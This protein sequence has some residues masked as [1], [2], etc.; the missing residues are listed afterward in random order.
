[1][2][3]KKKNPPDREKVLKALRYCLTITP[4]GCN[5]CPYY[6]ATENK[7]CHNVLYQDTLELLRK[8]DPDGVTGL[9]RKH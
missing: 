6:R 2:A 1:M 9:Q 4:E 8:E 5:G 7:R 3:T